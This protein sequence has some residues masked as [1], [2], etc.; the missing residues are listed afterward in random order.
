MKSPWFNSILMLGHL[1]FFNTTTLN[2]QVLNVN[3]IAG[4]GGNY[5]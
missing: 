3:L 5:L 4:G 1:I 2:A